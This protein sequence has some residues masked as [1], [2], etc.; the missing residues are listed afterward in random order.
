MK[1]FEKVYQVLIDK[2]F[3]Y[4]P[5]IFAAILIL[6]IGWY[7]IKFIKK[8]AQN[9]LEKKKTDPT[10]IAFLIELFVIFLKVMLFISVVSKLGVE[11][12]TFVAILGAAGLAIGLALQGSLSNFA[13]GVLIIFLK[14]FKVG[15]LI[16]AQG[17]TGVV[18]KILIFNTILITLDNQTIYIPNGILSNGTVINITKNGTRRVDF[19]L[20]IKNQ[21]Q[22]AFAIKICNELII[23]N[24]LVIKTQNPIVQITEI[25]EVFTIISIQIWAKNENYNQLKS[26]MLLKIN[27]EFVIHKINN[28]E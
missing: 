16:T 18:N 19:N 13:G 2:I 5:K 23:K 14:P 7:A 10:L 26:D 21:N 9:H 11:S 28:H 25:T 1:N 24:E 4:T 3:A 20:K 8:I 22:V 27:E 17:H 12:S 6:V 15:D